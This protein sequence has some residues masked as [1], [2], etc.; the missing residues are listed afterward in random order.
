M[1]KKEGL[2][3]EAEERCP[4]ALR[5]PE[6]IL[7]HDTEWGVPVRDD[8]KHFEFLLLESMQA[9]LSWLTVLRKRSNFAKAFAGFD[10][11]HIAAFDAAKTAVLLTD[12]GIIRNRRK[13]EAAI[14]N[15]RAFLE[16]QRTFGSFDAFIWDF[17]GGRPVQNNWKRMEDVP[18]VTEQAQRLA[19]EL[20]KRGFAFLG[21][22]TV[23]AHMQAS[24]LVNDHLSSCFRHE[25][26]RALGW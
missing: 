16:L 15:A 1:S 2:M 19:K 21:P 12:P 5:S 8:L 20:K 22:T 3:P 7:Y 17:M 24:G 26:V 13:V 6:E 14:T 9:G 23:Y 18:A 4:W 11:V 25:Q 10:P